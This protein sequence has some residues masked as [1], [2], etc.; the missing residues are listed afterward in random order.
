MN[1]LGKRYLFFALSILI[2]LP[3]LIMLAVNGM[4]LSIDFKGGTLLE[5]SFENGVF[6]ST[7]AIKKIYDHNG[8]NDLQVQSTTEG[9]LLLRS[10]ELSDS[11]RQSVLDVLAE[12]AG[13][14]V[15]IL[16]SDT[17]G[18]SIGQGV[19]CSFGGGNLHH[20]R[21]SR[22]TARFSLWRVRHYRHGPRCAHR[23]R[24]DRLRSQV[25]RLASRFF[26]P[27]RST[28]SHRFFSPG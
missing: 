13:S 8:I 10:S 12:E 27:Y 14:P 28:Y 11:V 4:P 24:L 26:I 3:G 5:V 18:P 2:I 25:L 20:L 6:P 21:L 23:S 7:E 19:T 22:G 15:I 9:T 17:V 1:I 16:K